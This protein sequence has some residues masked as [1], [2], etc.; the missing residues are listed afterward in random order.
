MDLENYVG[1]GKY[2]G[3]WMG[4]EYL[5]DDNSPV[6]KEN[7]LKSQFNIQDSERAYGGG[8]LTKLVLE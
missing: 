5:R 7:L 4:K 8:V 2:G 3:Y 1:L 6:T